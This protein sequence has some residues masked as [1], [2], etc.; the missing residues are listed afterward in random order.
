QTC[1]EVFG[2][3]F[4][5]LGEGERREDE[6]F[7]L[8]AL[9][10]LSGD[11]ALAER[12]AREKETLV[13]PKLDRGEHFNVAALLADIFVETGRPK[14]ALKVADDFIK[15]QDAWVGFYNPLFLENVRYRAGAVTLATF[16]QRRAEWL[17]G[18]ERTI[19]RR[20]E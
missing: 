19:E 10:S 14:L 15:R 17:D 5:R 20:G 12:Y 18:Q 8:A 3:S 1:R 13:A 7:H 16:E 2:Q 4:A 6:L 9:A 11:F